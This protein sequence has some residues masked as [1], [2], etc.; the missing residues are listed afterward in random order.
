MNSVPSP[1]RPDRILER[2]ARD[3]AFERRLPWRVEELREEAA[4]AYYAAE[5]PPTFLGLPP[6]QVSRAMLRRIYEHV[7]NAAGR[8]DS[9][10]PDQIRPTASQI[11][12]GLEAFTT[13]Q[14]TPVERWPPIALSPPMG[15]WPIFEHRYGLMESVGLEE[16][17]TL[18]SYIRRNAGE[19]KQRIGARK[20]EAIEGRAIERSTKLWLDENRS[21]L[22]CISH[23]YWAKV[24]RELAREAN[25]QRRKRPGNGR[26]MAELGSDRSIAERLSKPGSK[27]SP[28]RVKQWR[29]LPHDLF[30]D[31]EDDEEKRAAAFIARLTRASRK[32]QRRK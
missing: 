5:P 21:K 9:L 24:L 13:K 22:M 7:S 17:E 16:L 29:E 14:W 23:P 3:V 30:D 12:A 15:G 6:E 18:R 28:N 25:R 1:E 11:D 31:E 10:P 26:S 20:I 8:M 19:L 2:I 32:Y 4:K 27:V